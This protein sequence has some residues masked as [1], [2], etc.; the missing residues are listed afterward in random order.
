[1]RSSQDLLIRT[2]RVWPVPIIPRGRNH[3]DAGSLVVGTLRSAA[4]VQSVVRV[5]FEGSADGSGGAERHCASRCTKDGCCISCQPCGRHAATLVELLCEPAE[6][7]RVAL[8]RRGTRVIDDLTLLD[9]LS[10]RPMERTLAAGPSRRALS[11]SDPGHPRRHHPEFGLRHVLRGMA[12][13]EQKLIELLE[14]QRRAEEE[15]A[16]REQLRTIQRAFREAPACL[17]RRGIRLVRYR[18][19]ET[20]LPLPIVVRD[21]ELR[22]SS[23]GFGDAAPGLGVLKGAAGNR[24]RQFLRFPRPAVQRGGLA[25]IGHRARRHQNG[26]ARPTAR[27]LTAP[28][29]GRFGI[30][31]ATRRRSRHARRRAESSG[32][33]FRAGGARPRPRQGDGPP[34]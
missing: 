2:R 34:A 6:T 24:Q 19:A 23:N 26:T 31:L 30:S 14:A 9:H 33:L 4:S 7:N 3:P 32:H 15:Q 1:M 22:T 8:Y 10:P 16:S 17:A 28:R 11:R 18:G 27:P 12:P 5:E 21:L 25:G 29:R 13:L 20:P